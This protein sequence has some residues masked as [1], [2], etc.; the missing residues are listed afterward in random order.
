MLD[1]RVA[2]A[3]W[4]PLQFPR[5]PCSFLFARVLS[6]NALQPNLTKRLG[7]RIPRRRG[8]VFDAP[9]G[10]NLSGGLVDQ[11]LRQV[12]ARESIA[13]PARRRTRFYKLFLNDQQDQAINCADDVFF[14]PPG[15]PAQARV[16]ISQQRL[17]IRRQGG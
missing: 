1:W 3:S 8:D 14:F 2:S 6:T 12:E 9:A 16:R 7:A 10:K 17:H 5:L 13:L 4:S 11:D 15:P